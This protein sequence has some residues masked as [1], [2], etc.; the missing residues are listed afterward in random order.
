MQNLGFN[1][2]SEGKVILFDVSVEEM[3][4]Y[5]RRLVDTDTELW[6]DL[7]FLTAQTHFYS[8]K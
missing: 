6:F 5:C 1:D 4:I 3:Q 8:A 7:A 2:D